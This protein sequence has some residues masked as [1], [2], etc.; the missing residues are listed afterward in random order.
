M[1]TPDPDAQTQRLPRDGD[2]TDLLL[3][4]VSHWQ[5]CSYQDR[6]QHTPSNNVSVHSER[7]DAER[8]IKNRL[9]P[10]EDIKRG[11]LSISQLSQ[12]AEEAAAGRGHTS[13]SLQQL[14]PQNCRK[15]YSH[16]VALPDL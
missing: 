11:Q 14:M 5:I 15:V 12:G 2:T 6:Q 7:F 9:S 3:F 8:K 1:G 4:Y 16:A 10:S 13:C